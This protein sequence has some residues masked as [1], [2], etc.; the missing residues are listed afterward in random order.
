[1]GY[2][3]EDI[4]IAFEVSDLSRYLAFTRTGH[5]VQ[6]LHVL[7]YP[8]IH[9]VKNLA[10]DTCY[11]RVTSDKNIQSKVQAMKDLYVDAGE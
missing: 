3:I 1:M 7:K 4:V 2:D 9:D 5:L 8:E 10:F 11:Q 6:D